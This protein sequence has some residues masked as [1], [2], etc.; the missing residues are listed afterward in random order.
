MTAI[1]QR[2]TFSACPCPTRHESIPPLSIIIWSQV[3]S[4]FSSVITTLYRFAWGIGF[5]RHTV[6]LH[7]KFLS[8]ILRKP[9]NARLICVDRRNSTRNLLDRRFIILVS[10]PTRIIRR[11][12]RTNRKTPSRL[13]SRNGVQRRIPSN[14]PNNSSEYCWEQQIAQTILFR[15][16]GVRLNIRCWRT[17]HFRFE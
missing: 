11:R 12:G 6:S 10:F 5:I 13:D 4:S 2:W 8:N 7:R 14:S 15:A 17:F 3:I 16:I 9:R 1:V